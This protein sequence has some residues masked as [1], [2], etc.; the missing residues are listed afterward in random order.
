MPIN[1]AKKTYKKKCKS[2]II[3]FY[4]HEQPLYEFSKRINFT[5]FVKEMLKSLKEMEDQPIMKQYERT[6]KNG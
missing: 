1:Q 3:D 4:L 2:R 5:K 6:N